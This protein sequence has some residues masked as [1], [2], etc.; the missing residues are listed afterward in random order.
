[1]DLN[2]PGLQMHMDAAQLLIHTSGDLLCA[3]IA[4]LEEH[5][6]LLTI[7]VEDEDLSSCEARRE[8]ASVGERS[9]CG[10]DVGLHRRLQALLEHERAAVGE[11]DGVDGIA[12]D[13]GRSRLLRAAEEISNRSERG[14][15][16]GVA[17]VAIVDCADNP[18]LSA[19]VLK[20]AHGGEGEIRAWGE[21]AKV[22]L[23][24]LKGADEER[25]SDGTALGDADSCGDGCGR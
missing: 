20:E 7:D 23:K 24:L 5:G 14:R 17:D 9:R 11:S 21:A 18:E 3:L 10:G 1:M 22:A 4:I 6:L 8:D 19:A 25:L 15:A 12:L 2:L 13:G 16:V